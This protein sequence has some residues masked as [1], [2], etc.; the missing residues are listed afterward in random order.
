[1]GLWDDQ[2]LPRVIDLALGRPVREARARV[3]A[4]LSG[5]VLE[6]G[7]GSGRSLAY[8]PADVTRLLAV[9][10]A[11]VGRRLAAGRVAAAPCPVEF[12]GDDGQALPLPDASVDHVLTAWTLCTIPDVDQALR[13]IHRVLRPGG[14][15]HFTEHGRS[16]RPAVARWQ[17]RLTP[18]WGRIAGGCHLD[19]R[20]D[21]LVAA[22]GLTLESA[23]TH[24]MRGTAR[25]GFAY[26]G[27]ASRP[28]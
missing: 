26:E 13:E 15:L 24:P 18:A 3:A 14:S 28:T 10:P 12:I 17:D 21:E 5:E 2:V 9:E 25:L 22:S 27:V 8:L 19:R 23:T 4:G 7:F 20:I 11:A 16:S 1:M 6:I